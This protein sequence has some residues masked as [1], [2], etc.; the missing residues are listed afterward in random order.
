[1]SQKRR[2]RTLGNETL[3]L[4]VAEVRESIAKAQDKQAALVVL[5]G[6]E[7]EIGSHVI[8]DKS[9]VVGRDPSA[10]LPLQDEGISRRHCQV[11]Y[12]GDHFVLE[13]LGSTNGTLL[14][15]ER[16]DGVVRLRPGDRIFLGGCVLKFTNSDAFEVRYHAQMDQL[17]GTDD[18]TGLVAKRRFDAAYIRGLDAA[19]ALRRSFAVLMLDLDQLKIINDTHGH[20][21][22]A[23]TISEVGR[24]IG[25]L[26]SEHGLACRFGGDEFAAFLPGSDK[27]QAV[28]MGETVRKAIVD[29]HF[30]KDGVVIKPT[31]SV[32]VAAYPDDGRT[33]EV[34][35]RCADEAL[36]R[37]K[38]G[39]RNRVHT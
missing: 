7:G 13:D 20:P 3:K 19:R 17:I 28:A 38:R 37:A 22:G 5:Q 14:N 34:L 18:L 2:R 26:V 39:G 4:N 35:L 15:G 10:E 25:R 31:V 1:M 27:A 21:I 11:S 36:Y 12:D 9:V 32:G 33:A 8:L 29:H 24:I 16:I 6:N 30:E 23:H